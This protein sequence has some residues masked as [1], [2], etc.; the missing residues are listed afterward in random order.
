MIRFLLYGIFGW[1]VEIL[2]TAGYA[3]VAAIAA[4]RR[5]DPKLQGHTY[6][7]MFFVYGGGGM[8]FE[9]AHAILAPLPWMVRGTVYMLGCFAVEYATGWAIKQLTGTIPWDYSAK[10]WQLHGLIRFDYAPAW[11]VFGLIL[12]QVEV[13]VKAVDPVLRGL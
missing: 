6:L 8:L 12:E 13:I 9:I 5:P 1:C 4:G 10:R 2:W 3:L 7:W 11:F